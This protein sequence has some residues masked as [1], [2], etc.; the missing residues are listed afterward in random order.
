SML[1][2]IDEEVCTTPAQG[3][4]FTDPPRPAEVTAHANGL[5]R[6]QVQVFSSNGSG[7]LILDGDDTRWEGV[8]PPYADELLAAWSLDRIDRGP[9]RANRC[10]YLWGIFGYDRKPDADGSR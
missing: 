6:E 5:N 1:Q 3:L 9:V 2:L 4:L 10:E 7:A 8:A